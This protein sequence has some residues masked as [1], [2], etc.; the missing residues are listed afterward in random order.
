MT[1][2]MSAYANVGVWEPDDDDEEEEIGAKDSGKSQLQGPGNGPNHHQEIQCDNIVWNWINWTF[3][4]KIAVL[5]FGQFL[6]NCS[7]QER[8]IRIFFKFRYYTKSANLLKSVSFQKSIDCWAEVVALLVVWLPPT[9][10]I[11]G[12]NPVIGQIYLLSTALKQK[13]STFHF[14][15]TNVLVKK[16]FWGNTFSN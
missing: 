9:P 6:S 8:Q 12:L 16:Y 1:F 11:P 13:I 7:R 2:D 3:P 5:H 10:E 4:V 14:L 15:C